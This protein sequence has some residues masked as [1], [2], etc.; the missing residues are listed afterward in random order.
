[1]R[2]TYR[3]VREALQK[4]IRWVTEALQ[5]PITWMYSILSN[6]LAFLPTT[7]FRL[8]RC[9]TR[10]R[11]LFTARTWINFASQ[12]WLT[13]IIGHY[14]HYCYKRNKLTN[15]RADMAKQL[16]STHMALQRNIWCLACVTVAHASSSMKYE[17]GWCKDVNL[18][19]QRETT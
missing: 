4:P 1:M 17:H 15:P 19:E 14:A 10:R 6:N 5:K 2:R 8:S 18:T 7:P 11:M 13:V 3:W 9:E 16:Q 12:C